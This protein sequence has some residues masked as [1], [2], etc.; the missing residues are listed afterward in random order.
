MTE[1]RAYAWSA[2]YADSPPG[3]VIIELRHADV[4]DV[5]GTV[6]LYIDDPDTFGGDEMVIGPFRPDQLA[7]LG[8]LILGAAEAAERWSR[9]T[10]R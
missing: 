7:E 5:R 4:G 3:E 9:D 1:H 6:G 2:D 10:A 8:Y